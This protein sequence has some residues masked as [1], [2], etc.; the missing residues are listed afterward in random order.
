MSVSHRHSHPGKSGVCW[1]SQQKLRA[2]SKKDNA[3]YVTYNY[4]SLTNIKLCFFNAKK[5]GL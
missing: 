2:Y 4:N 1:H 5:Q 3:G